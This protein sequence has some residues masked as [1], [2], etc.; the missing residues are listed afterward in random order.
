MKLLIADRDQD[1]RIGI[2]WLV[3]AN[4]FSFE[5]ILLASSFDELIIYLE[6]DVPEV[7][8]L[9]LDMIPREHWNILL[10]RIKQYTQIVIAVSAE[11]TYERAKQA[12]ELQAV[13]LLVKPNSPE[14]LKK[15]LYRSVNVLR[16]EHSSKQRQ[17]NMYNTTTYRSLFIQDHQNETADSIMVLQTEDQNKLAEL[18]LFLETYYVMEDVLLLP[19]SDLIVLVFQNKNTKQLE[20][21]G[22][23]LL[24]DWDEE[25]N[26]PMAIVIHSQGMIKSLHEAY[27]QA[28]GALQ[29]TYFKGYRQL[30]HVKQNVEW[31]TIDP[32]LTPQE[33]REWIDML[34][35]KDK[36]MVKSWMY[37]H[38]L[39]ISEP[40]PEPGLVRTRLTS[41]LAQIRRYMKSFYLDQG[42][43]E[44]LYHKVFEEIL[45]SP[46]LYRSVQQMILFT[47]HLFDGAQNQ[48]ESSRHDVVELGV[49]YIE[50]NYHHQ[51]LSLEDVAKYTGR[52]PSYFSHLLN[53]KMNISFIQLVTNLRIHAA[54]RL[55][56]ET[57]LSIKEV[58]NKA[59][60]RNANY[61][62]RIFKQ[63]MG[64]TPR[65]YRMEK[66]IDL[67]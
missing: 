34:N 52:S 54:K 57:D 30:I 20:A 35:N 46:V 32:F 6:N 42:V 18:R 24:Q 4:S 2:R 27:M 63:V 67:N 13:D 7:T 31:N 28:K 66:D 19:I 26:E 47:G 59:G 33:Q 48:L 64:V 55:L 61:F 39:S 3:S 40:F 17:A 15:T 60:F 11:A 10:S 12:I 16:A 9:E 62:S 41:I 56:W 43:Y 65:E 21:V 23:R 50:R 25:K 38:F 5:Q 49:A 51:T 8:I 14:S 44:E 36:D 58:A 37:R 53:K 22:N 29:V 45:Y 1:E